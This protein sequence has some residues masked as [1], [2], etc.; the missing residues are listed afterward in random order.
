MRQQFLF[1]FLAA[2]F[3]VSCTQAEESQL[4][5]ILQQ[6]ES[7]D[8]ST[9]KSSIQNLSKK[10][11]TS[12]EALSAL[13]KALQDTNWQVRSV[14]ACA[15]GKQGAGVVPKLL[16]LLA[17]KDEG[18][19]IGATLALAEIGPDAA[20]AVST[21]CVMLRGDTWEAR[22]AALA[23][24]NRIGPSAR[25]AVPLLIGFL[26]DSN[27]TLRMLATDALGS[28]GIDDKGAEAGLLEA[29]GDTSPELKARVLRALAHCGVSSPEALDL[30]AKQ[31]AEKN[32]RVKE[33]AAELLGSLGAKAA[34]AVTALSAAL[35]EENPEVRR[36]CAV[37]LGKIGP[38]AAPAIPALRNIVFGAPWVAVEGAAWD[39][40]ARIGPATVPDLLDII[41]Q[42]DY[43][44]QIAAR[45]A[46][47]R[48][49]TEFPP[50]AF[51]TAL[52]SNKDDIRVAAARLLGQIQPARQE[53]VLA[54]VEACD[55]KVNEVRL[56]AADAL[57]N[58]EVDALPSVLG[59]LKDERTRLR[60]QAASILAKSSAVSNELVPLLLPL[61]DDPQL[62][63]K[64]GAVTAL[65][66]IGSGAKPAVPKLLTLL[67]APNARPEIIVA[68]CQTLEHIGGL[69][70]EA[71]KPLAATLSNKIMQVRA[72][73]APALGCVVGRSNETAVILGTLLT[74]DEDPVKVACARGL[75]NLGQDAKLVAVQLYGALLSKEG[76][77]RAA[78]A[79]ALPKVLDAQTAVAKLLPML[80]DAD[81][82]VRIGVVRALGFSA[83]TAV[84]ASASLAESLK[85][86]DEQVRK[87]AIATMAKAGAT[88]NKALAL[89]LADENPS[90]RLR[91]VKALNAGGPMARDALPEL[92][93]VIKTGKYR[94]QEAALNQIKLIRPYE[95]S[96]VPDLLE[97]LRA[98]AT[99]DDMRRQIVTFLGEM[100]DAAAKAVPDLVLELR[101][102]KWKTRFYAT[103]ALG[104][105]GA[106]A[107]P[108]LKALLHDPAPEVQ[109]A[110]AKAIEVMG[111]K[112][113]ASI[114][115]MVA[116]LKDK[117]AEVQERA[118]NALSK[119]GIKGAD[120]VMPL[121]E[122]QDKMVQQR[123]YTVLCRIGKECLPHAQKIADHLWLPDG[124]MAMDALAS[125]GPATIPIAL[126][127]LK[128][129]SENCRKRA[130]LLLGRMGDASGDVVPGLIRILN[131]ENWEVQM[132]SASALG[133]LG[134]ASAP[135]LEK[136]NALMAPENKAALRMSVLRTFEAIGPKAAAALA[137]YLSDADASIRLQSF[138]SLKHLGP[139]AIGALLNLQTLLIDK[140]PDFRKQAV[141]VVASIG[142][143]AKTALVPLLDLCDDADATVATGAQTAIGSIGAARA[144]DIPALIGAAKSATGNKQLQAIRI[145][146]ATGTPASAAI[147]DL[148]PL[149]KADQKLSDAANS[150]IRFISVAEPD[151]KGILLQMLKDTSWKV[152]SAVAVVLKNMQVPNEG[153]LALVLNEV[154]AVT[155][156]HEYA[157]AQEIFFNAKKADGA[158]EFAMRLSGDDSLYEKKVGSK[159]RRF[160]SADLASA[161]VAD[162]QPANGGYRYRIIKVG[163]PGTEWAFGGALK[164][165]H[166]LIAYPA[167][168]GETG[169]LTFMISHEKKIFAADFGVRTLETATKITSFETGGNWLPLI[170]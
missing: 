137:T 104:R 114:P 95:A 129:P 51:L 76:E 36:K 139:R 73:A 57:K 41:A 24:L 80:K 143:E 88:G 162:D 2:F 123:A 119:N 84:L 55:D 68:T 117:D 66:Q 8:I 124:P 90:I 99:V 3:V 160:I 61:L 72:S 74:S 150:A 132:A 65:G 94:S 25:E 78:V 125:I 54:L 166:A 86:S 87:E 62:E 92:L 44:R 164:N 168:H 29:L 89:G 33:S 15:V 6:S 56:A 42:T 116:S 93:Q 12:P 16:Q 131:D 28:I 151:K 11:H 83:E 35:G 69:Y 141:A 46:L 165:G 34:P 126:E 140:N 50:A 64:L 43:R 38:A 47:T 40:L 136:L 155:K 82:R 122:D 27:L 128:D 22:C 105:I 1:T 120:A 31:L 98:P 167:K 101:T 159:D 110:A 118:I 111:S 23:A 63:V 107:E 109:K 81:S 144:D 158:G 59:M 133:R 30:V 145:L 100:E 163:P 52:K 60:A 146:G 67:E 108:A 26:K 112:G 48:I 156:L 13:L 148:L 134:E 130:A 58:L 96:I 9:R 97:A 7:P 77:V 121:L 91:T 75:G 32:D 157:A 142:S 45:V 152:R 170:E 149:L 4:S 71:F 49:A 103:T 39:A 127:K 70:A 161:D 102:N 10:A 169:K 154:G 79:E 147:P 17:S 37:A 20:P 53:V 153:E 138:R 115:D 14:A 18:A 21:L 5:T 106:P 113:T 85:D 135:A 19:R